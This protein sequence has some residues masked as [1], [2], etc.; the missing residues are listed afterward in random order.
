MSNSQNL[1]D[2]TNRKVTIVIK[3]FL[4]FMKKFIMRIAWQTADQGICTFPDL[5]WPFVLICN[6]LIARI[7]LDKLAPMK[8]D[9]PTRRE[10]THW[11]HSDENV[12][13][14]LSFP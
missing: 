4:C 2:F 12:S 13:S 9:C 14:G 6:S 7:Y 8:E 5:S 3:T 11:R 10:Q 1:L